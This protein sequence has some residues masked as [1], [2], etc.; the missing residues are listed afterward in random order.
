MQNMNVFSMVDDFSYQDPTT[1]SKAFLPHAWADYHVIG[2][3]SQPGDDPFFSY[4][5]PGNKNITPPKHSDRLQDCKMQ[6]KNADSPAAADWLTKN[7][8]CRILCHATMYDVEYNFDKEPNN[9]LG[10]VAGQQIIDKQP[11]AVGATPMDAL[12]A[13]CQSHLAVDKKAGVT[14]GMMHDLEVDLLRLQT[15]LRETEDDDVDGIQAAQDENLEH[16]F[17]KIDGGTRYHYNKR[18]NLSSQP[19][20]GPPNVPTLTDI[21]ALQTLNDNQAVFDNV[22][23][24]VAS[25]RWQLFAEFWNYV[26]GFIQKEFLTDYTSDVSKI[27]DRLDSLQSSDQQKSR[28]AYLTGRI[29]SAL[30]S[31]QQL[32]KGTDDRF[33]QAKSVYITTLAA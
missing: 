28:L 33:F 31:L 18:N 16:A 15:L 13:Y 9:V 22:T 3:H 12:L 4:V 2:W 20:G 27:F 32:A 10:R 24:E 26:S 6:L 11:I 1:Q 17:S 19:K 30:S 7:N 21:A 23:R 25:K 14:T 29:T 5:D 8:S